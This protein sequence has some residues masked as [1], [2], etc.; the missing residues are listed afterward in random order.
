MQTPSLGN[1]LY[2]VT[3]I[4]DFYR[5]AWVYNLK[6]KSCKF[7][8]FKIS[9]SMAE[10]DSACDIPEQNGVADMKNRSL[11]EIARCMI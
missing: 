7:S 6:S 8:C 3:F 4:D 2:F 9:L 1:Y 5:H 10:N 11:V